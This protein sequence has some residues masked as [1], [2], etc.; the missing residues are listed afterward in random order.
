MFEE[1]FPS[2]MEQEQER[3]KKIAAACNRF[4]KK[5]TATENIINTYLFL[6]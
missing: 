6:L 1:T 4:W 3:R 5:N 2:I